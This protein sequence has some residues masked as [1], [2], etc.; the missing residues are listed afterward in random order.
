VLQVLVRVQILL[1]LPSGKSR[2]DGKKSSRCVASL[3]FMSMFHMCLCVYLCVCVC[4]LV[5]VCARAYSG[6]YVCV[7]GVYWY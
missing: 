3:C 7:F 2:Q 5:C 1:Q 4:V 6:V